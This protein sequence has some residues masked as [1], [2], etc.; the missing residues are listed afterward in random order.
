MTGA[1][2]LYGVVSSGFSA[3]KFPQSRVSGPLFPYSHGILEMPAF[4]RLPY[5]IV[6][7]AGTT[8]QNHCHRAGPRFS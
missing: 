5:L 1:I 2:I 7:Y 6:R 3:K 4:Y 8:V